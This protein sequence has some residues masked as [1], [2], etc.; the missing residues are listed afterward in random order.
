MH[1]GYT[2]CPLPAHDD[3]H[4]SCKVGLDDPTLWH[5]HP[6][7]TGTNILHLGSALSG[8]ECHGADFK[9]LVRWIADRVDTMGSDDKTDT[10]QQASIEAPQRP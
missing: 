1:R 10:T 9:R 7:S 6:C 4:A 8:I 2:V 5:C 3:R